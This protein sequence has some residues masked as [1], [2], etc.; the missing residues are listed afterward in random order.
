MAWRSLAV[1]EGD[2]VGGG[3]LVEVGGVVRSENFALYDGEEDL[4]FVQPGRMDRQ[5]DQPRG[6]NGLRV[7]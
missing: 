2:Q 1:L 4:D 3:E 6:A 7:G 5:L